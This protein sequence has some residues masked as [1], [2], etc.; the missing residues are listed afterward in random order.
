MDI[1]YVFRYAELHGKR[2]LAVSSSVNLMFV[3]REK[4]KIEIT[5]PNKKQE[6]QTFKFSLLK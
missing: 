5:L 4:W 6:L 2:F 1:L 3:I